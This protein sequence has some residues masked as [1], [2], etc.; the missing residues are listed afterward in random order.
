M[1]R[2]TKQIAMVAIPSSPGNAIKSTPASAISFPMI[3]LGAVVVGT[4]VYLVSEQSDKAAWIF[5]ILLL[6][7]IAYAQRNFGSEITALL[8]GK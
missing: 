6:L 4:A 1:E 3:A 8:A 7:G 5:T 2:A